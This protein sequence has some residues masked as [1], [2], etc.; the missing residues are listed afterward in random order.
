MLCRLAFDGGAT[1]INQLDY[2]GQDPHLS[3]LIGPEG[4]FSPTEIAK[5]QKKDFKIMSL[6]PR[7]LDDRR[8]RTHPQL[9]GFL[10]GEIHFAATR[11]GL[12]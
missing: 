4:G 8:D 11:E 1:H 3:L 10:N 7:I 6:G 9:H 5:S 12:A 2:L